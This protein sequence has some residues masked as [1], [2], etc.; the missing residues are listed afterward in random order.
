MSLRRS[1]VEVLIRYVTPYLKFTLVSYYLTWYVRTSQT[2][3]TITTFYL[4]M[5][6]YPE[7]YKR[8][9]EEVD[10]V[11]GHGRLPSY[12]DR[13]NLP[14]VDAVLKE[15]LRWETVLP[16]SLSTLFSVIRF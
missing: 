11:V 9:Q 14:Y 12:S 10:R 1:M 16:T 8:L 15:T 6:L 4:A 5:T 3:I 13:P 7:V 2:T